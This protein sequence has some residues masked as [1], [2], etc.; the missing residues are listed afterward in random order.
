MKKTNNTVLATLGH[1]SWSKISQS[2][3]VSFIQLFLPAYFRKL[4]RLEFAEA[5]LLQG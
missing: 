4:N 2:S 1:L 3:Y 5:F